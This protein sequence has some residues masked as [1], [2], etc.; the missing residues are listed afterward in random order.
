MRLETIRKIV[1]EWFCMENQWDFNI[2]KSKIYT[3]GWNNRKKDTYLHTHTRRD[4]DD[5]DDGGNGKGRM[6]KKKEKEVKE[7]I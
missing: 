4:D 3:S 5:D 2:W 7:K 6:E 1:C